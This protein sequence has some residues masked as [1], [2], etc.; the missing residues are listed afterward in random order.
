MLRSLSVTTSLLAFVAFILATPCSSA[1]ARSAMSHVGSMPARNGVIAPRLYIGNSSASTILIYTNNA[2]PKVIGT[3][4][5][6]ISGPTG[7]SVDGGGNLY[8]ANS[9]GA[10]VT[11][12]AP[13]TTV[14]SFKIFGGLVRPNNVAIGNDGTV[15]VTDFAGEVQE[16]HPGATQPFLTIPLIPANSSPSASNTPTDVGVDAAGDLYVYYD[17]EQY[18]VSDGF[19]V[20]YPPGQIVGQTLNNISTTHGGGIDLDRAGNIAIAWP[21]SSRSGS[22]VAVY[23]AGTI[24][25]LEYWGARTNPS[26]LRLGANED[27]VYTT[28]SYT[29]AVRIYTYPEGR[30]IR[31]ISLQ[32][33]SSSFTSVAVAPAHSH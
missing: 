27:R 30:L 8:V 11:V 5:D 7:M 31:K 24:K 2:H 21:G 29:N 9:T 10:D 1:Q 12:Y 4:T 14:P 3:I 19:V 28:D 33:S 32:P 13:G 16:Y 17:Y 18:I 26:Q 25:R 23:A 20:E 6:G 15:Y 22:G